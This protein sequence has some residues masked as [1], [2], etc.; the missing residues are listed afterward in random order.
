MLCKKELKSESPKA[1]SGATIRSRKK[2]RAI[3]MKIHNLRHR[4][5]DISAAPRAKR[6]KKQRQTTRYKP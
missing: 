6:K 2:T 4:R 3:S 1:K 5:S